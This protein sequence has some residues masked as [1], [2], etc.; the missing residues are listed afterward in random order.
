VGPPNG[1]S[2]VCVKEVSLLVRGTPCP[3]PMR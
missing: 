2:N 1:L 3:L